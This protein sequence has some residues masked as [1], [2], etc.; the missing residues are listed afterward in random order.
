MFEK[1][2]LGKGVKLME[3]G[4]KV[5]GPEYEADI[6]IKDNESITN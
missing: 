2:S 6:D 1:F 5:T 3:N 4:R